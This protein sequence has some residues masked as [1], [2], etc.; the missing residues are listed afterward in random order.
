MG[1]DGH[2][3]DNGMLVVESK[4]IIFYPNNPSDVNVEMIKNGIDAW[5][6]FDTSD[7]Y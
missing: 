5:S 6:L 4:T 1:V 7:G 2:F 3:D